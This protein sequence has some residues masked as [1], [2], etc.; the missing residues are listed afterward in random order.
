MG[1]LMALAPGPIL[2][3]RADAALIITFAQEGSGVVATG[4]GTVNLTGLKMDVSQPCCSDVDSGIGTAILGPNNGT[5]RDPY[6]MFF[7]YQGG[8]GTATG[9][10]FASSGTGPGTGLSG[11]YD[12]LFVPLGYVSGTL[13]TNTTTY[14]NQPFASLDLTTGTF[15]HTYS[16]FNG[17]TTLDTFVVQVGQ[18]VF[19]EPP[20]MAM[21]C[22]A[23]GGVGMARRLG[24][25]A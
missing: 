10:T 22:L 6:E 24:R 7:S 11:A 4:V 2:P 20:S 18:S 21:T 25:R 12:L 3:G 16:A 17:G 5:T 14:A 8:F 23:L 15:T 19:P 1:A 13:I 9:Y